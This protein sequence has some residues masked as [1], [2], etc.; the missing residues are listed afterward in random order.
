MHVIYSLS[1]GV[2]VCVCVSECVLERVRRREQEGE[3]VRER[4]RE[5]LPGYKIKRKFQIT[6]VQ[7]V[8]LC[9]A[10]QSY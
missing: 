10:Q 9:E 2:G 7:V 4:G 5:R 1:A 3:C 6:F 8:N